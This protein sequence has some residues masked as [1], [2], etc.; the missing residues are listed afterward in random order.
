MY[1]SRWLIIGVAILAAA[2]SSNET[3][4]KIEPGPYDVRIVD[5]LTLNDAVQG[6]DVTLRVLYP[7]GA[8]PF[9]LVVYSTGAFC[10]PQM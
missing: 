3:L 2:A 5:E 4:Y 1:K 10:W 6:R 8:G 7:A 9:P